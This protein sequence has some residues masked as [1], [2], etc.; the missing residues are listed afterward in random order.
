MYYDEE[1]CKFL[2]Q[3]GQIILRFASFFANDGTFPGLT[4]GNSF[5]TGGINAA[6]KRES[7]QKTW[8]LSLNRSLVCR[9]PLPTT[10]YKSQSDSLT[11]QSPEHR[12]R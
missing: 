5:P 6:L 2:H 10:A 1:L 3:Q 11:A 8:W 4:E 12:A 9:T 7:H